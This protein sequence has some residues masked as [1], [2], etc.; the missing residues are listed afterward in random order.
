MTPQSCPLTVLITRPH[1]Q[2]TRFAAQL[3]QAF[4][5]QVAPVISPLIAP[6]FLHPDLPQ[7]PF[8]AVVLSSETGAQAADA[9]RQCGTTL[10]DIA[11]CVGDHTAETARSFGFTAHSAA[12]DVRDLLALV[13]QHR[14]HGPFLH[15]RGRET[16]GDL[17]TDIRAAGLQAQAAIVY[18]QD[19]QRLTA[20]AIAL[21]AA[22]DAPLCVPL[23]SPR[24]AR[25]FCEA[26]A[27][28][29]LR[30]PL[31]VVAISEA[32]AREIPPKI[33]QTITI[34]AHPDAPAMMKAIAAT[35]FKP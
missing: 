33:A 31:L 17:V 13:V 12:G 29:T 14:Q 16:T 23:F 4:G 22:S 6:T 21:L 10:P 18:A 34:A 7:G 3:A 25:L 24:S 1:A 20:N 30:A 2:A 35:C 8:G 11:F 28:E 27:G 32:A 15:L 5:D 26:L 19:R 9:L